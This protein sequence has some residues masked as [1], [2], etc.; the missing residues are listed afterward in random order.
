MTGPLR[1]SEFAITAGLLAAIGAVHIMTALLVL[2]NAPGKA[3]NVQPPDA[4]VYNPPADLFT[5]TGWADFTSGFW[6]GGCGG[7]VFAW[8]LVGT[9]HLDTI[10]PI[11]KNVWTAG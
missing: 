8:L 9:L 10:M 6:L 3:P 11:I 1:N 2:Y 7:A 5:R 4:T